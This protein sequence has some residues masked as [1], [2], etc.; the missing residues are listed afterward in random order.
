MQTLKSN[1]VLVL[2]IITLAAFARLVPS[3]PNFAPITALAVFGGFA[4]FNKRLAY[5]VPMATML[6]SDVILALIKNDWGYAF[7]SAQIVV[8]LTLLATVAISVFA[9]RKQSVLSIAGST[10]IGSLL[11]FIT[12]NFAVWAMGTLYTHS[13]AGLGE[14]YV[15]AIPF[16]RNSFIADVMYVTAMF[17]V[18]ALLER[19]AFK[20]VKA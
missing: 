10:V 11:F 8:Y 20:P 15:A 16:L 13:L 12:T 9:S 4:F 14:C 7:H 6:V 3:I 1:S 5:L 2:A 19:S 18:F 17:G